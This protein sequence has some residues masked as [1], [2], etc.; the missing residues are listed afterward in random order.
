MEGV[1]INKYLADTGV[2]S[3]RGADRLVEEG[4]VT[5]DGKVAVMGDGVLPGQ[6][7]A[8][9]GVEAVQEEESVL[10]LL[11]KPVGVTCTTDPDDETNVVDFVGYPKRVFPVGRLDKDSE[12]LLLLTNRG[13]LVNG[14]MRSRYDHEKEYDV[15]VDKPLTKRF[16]EGMATGVPILDTVTKPCVIERTGSK[17]FTIVITQGLNRQIRRMCEHFGYEVVSLKRVR[18]HTV[19]LENLKPGEWRKA[20]REEKKELFDLAVREA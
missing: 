15:R 2:C 5:I 12:G 13:E 7:V 1:R 3:R 8:V 18:I 9:D 16:L 10:L 11:N 4:R 20:T 17:R 19:T 14:L 6:T